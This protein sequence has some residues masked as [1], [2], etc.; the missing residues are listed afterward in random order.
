M[1]ISGRIR[2]RDFIV[3]CF[4]VTSLLVALVPLPASIMDLL[5]ALN[6][7]LGVI[8]LLTTFFVE[9]P[10]DFSIF[11]TI[12]LITTLFRLVLNIATTRLILTRAGDYGELA[13]GQVI[14]SF[15]GFVTGESLVVGV[16]IFSLFIVI[17]FIVITKGATRISE[18]AAR[19]TLDAMPGR[20]MA[21]DADL[22]A[23]MIT[24]D[25]ARIQRREL[26]EQS[27]FFGAMDGASKFVRGD[28]I[29]SIIITF[30]NIL[31]GLFVGIVQNGMAVDGALAL[32]TTLTIGDG[33]VSQVPALL[34]SLAT[35]ILV[36]RSRDANNLSDRVIKQLFMKPEILA[37]TAGFLGILALTGLPPLPLLA[38]GA[39]CLMTAIIQIRR[40]RSPKAEKEEILPKQE[41]KESKLER[42]EDYLTIDPIA[43]EIGV[44]LLSLA[45]SSQNDGLLKRILRL[46]QETASEL[47]LLLPK[48]RVRDSLRLDDC[49]YQIKIYGELVAEGTLYPNMVLVRIPNNWPINLAGLRTTHPVDGTPAMWIEEK[50]RT[51]AEKYGLEI[52]TS[53]TV[54]EQ[55]LKGVIYREADQFLTRDA[56][57]HLLD[58]LHTTT[59]M[60]VDELVPKIMTVTEVQQ[61]LRLLLKEQVPVRRLGAILETLG[62]AAVK[63]KDPLYLIEQVRIRLSRTICGRLRDEDHVLHAILCAPETEQMIQDNIGRDEDELVVH[64][65]PE[66]ITTL[67]KAI[68]NECSRMNVFGFPPVL[69]TNSEVRMAFRKITFSEFPTLNILSF[70]EISNDTSVMSEGTVSC[71]YNISKK[72]NSSD[73]A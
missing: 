55:H 5:L 36:T 6:I 48:V 7:S 16:V 8:I 52:L 42:I 2:V 20:Q 28:A 3:P 33:L 65:A 11:P 68:K 13:A 24:E 32:Y 61:I 39:C 51:I 23:G 50:N 27:D 66:F 72:E 31:G 15:S 63:C 10:L 1:N 14:K 37:I 58:E 45:D 59:P 43:L 12:L 21:I 69:L 67:N 64:L 57:K 49:Q 30:I 54:L 41:K 38:L 22:N 40:D 4:A 46:R 44:G 25:Q 47:G 73:A 35:G 29:A 71:S 17:Q 9:K 60:V 18:V 19:F 26:T 34:I 70:K 62:D 56:V 53:R